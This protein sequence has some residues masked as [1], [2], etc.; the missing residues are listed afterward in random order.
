MPSHRFR[1]SCV[2]P[3]FVLRTFAVLLFTVA[4]AACGG[5]ESPAADAVATPAA[6]ELPAAT[7]TASAPEA[8]PAA[9]IESD[10]GK[11]PPPASV[12]TG[13]AGK[14]DPASRDGMY[15]SPPEMAIDPNQFY[16]ATLKTDR[17]DVKVQL[18]ADR[19]P[20]TVNNFVYL[21][22]EGFY[23]NTTFHR[24]LDGFMAQAGDPT[25]TG[26]GGP[27]Y[28]FEDEFALDLVF[29][30]PGLLAMA[31]SGPATN[32][33]Q[34]FVTFAP[35]EWLSG[36]HT[37]FGE[38]VEGQEV[39]DQLTRRDPQTLP[40][41]PGDTLYTVVIEEGDTSL[42]PTPTP[43]PPT[44]TPYA[45]SS[46]D[47]TDRP[48]AA[49]EP[50]ARGGFFNSPPETM[51]EAGQ[52]YTAVIATTQGDMVM[53][54]YADQAPIAVNNF[55]VLAN[56]GFFDNMPINVVSPDN[57]LVFGIP[58]NDPNNP[59]DV[60]Y[61]FDAEVGVAVDPDIGALSYYPVAQNA[62]GSLLSSGSILRFALF[63]VP[64]DAA[65]FNGFFGQVVEGTDVLLQL[66]TEDVIESITIVTDEQ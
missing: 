36:M 11:V 34:F 35:T 38:V 52:T 62:D 44:P 18:F 8:A 9:A 6:A 2:S 60:G 59:N 13:A 28:Q 66:T 57:S 47:S 51:I 7:A 24:V 48:L 21:A 55:V 41:F 10:P 16:Y 42:L 14:L 31:N 22:R 46:L 49:L 1:P 19:A 15:T 5:S 56:L 53:S 63:D 4:L 32:G 61:V 54:L 3:Q 40:D 27:G 43:A 58:S 23:D 26:A 25:G 29:D 50:A 65:Q 12:D 20:Q 39:L 37:I 64:A 17:G 33:S 30:R 45:P